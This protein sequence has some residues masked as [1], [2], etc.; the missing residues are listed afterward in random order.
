MGLEERVNSTINSMDP[1]HAMLAVSWAI[2]GYMGYLLLPMYSMYLV[3][4]YVPMIALGLFG[5][6]AA[7]SVRD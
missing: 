2:M 6:L 5:Y 3:T 1:H 7:K 4:P